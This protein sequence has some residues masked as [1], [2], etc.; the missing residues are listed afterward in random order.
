[1]LIYVAPLQLS[2]CR[3]YAMMRVL[4]ISIGCAKRDRGYCNAARSSLACDDRAFVVKQT[5]AAE[6][7]R[8]E[9]LSSASHNFQR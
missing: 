9:D 5:F 1:M 3:A 7:F 6:S 4:A 2:H 8:L